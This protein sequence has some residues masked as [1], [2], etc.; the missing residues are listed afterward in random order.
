MTILMKTVSVVLILSP[1]I[2]FTK[3]ATND[4]DLPTEETVV[5]IKNLTQCINSV[6]LDPNVENG[7]L[8]LKSLYEYYN[9]FDDIYWMM[10]ENDND[11][12]KRGFYYAKQ[13]LD[14]GMPSLLLKSVNFDHLKVR[15]EWNDRSVQ[16]LYDVIKS[17][18]ALREN[19]EFLYNE[20][21]FDDFDF[22]TDQPPDY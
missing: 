7:N 9:N 1:V 17:M 13:V 4:E 11:K 6:L 10:K 18:K 16:E 14:Y 19:V 8:L 21:T 12:K 3:L 20:L 22:G 15:F 5:C 2:I